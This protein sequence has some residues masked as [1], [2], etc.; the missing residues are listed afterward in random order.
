MPCGGRG[1]VEAAGFELPLDDA[2]VADELGIVLPNV[3]EESLGV[4]A[5]NEHVDGVTKRVIEAAP[6]IADHEDDHRDHDDSAASL[7]AV[8]REEAPCVR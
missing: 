4:L 8:A 7:V 6:D 5:T 2:K 3:V 1:L